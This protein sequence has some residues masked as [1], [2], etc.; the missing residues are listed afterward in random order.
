MLDRV[1]TMEHVDTHSF[2]IHQGSATWVDRHDGS[3]W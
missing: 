1:A 3:W 2:G